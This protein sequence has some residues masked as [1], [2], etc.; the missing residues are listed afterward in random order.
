METIQKGLAEKDEALD[1]D[2]DKGGFELG[3]VHH[4]LEQSVKAKF[5]S[6]K[7]PRDLFGQSSGKKYEKDGAIPLSQKDLFMQEEED[8]NF[9]NVDITKD[10]SEKDGLFT[11]LR[12]PKVN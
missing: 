9:S 2:C 8:L 10:N 12:K 7:K 1:V 3:M 5:S 6:E 4:L 11:K